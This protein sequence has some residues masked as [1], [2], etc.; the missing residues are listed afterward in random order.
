MKRSISLLGMAALCLALVFQSCKKDKMSDIVDATDPMDHISSEALEAYDKFG[1][2]LEKAID[3]ALESEIFKFSLMDLTLKKEMGDYET[4]MTTFLDHKTKKGIKMK[5]IL[6]EHAIGIFDEE[7]LDNFLREYPALIIATRGNLISWA[8]NEYVAPVVFVHSGFDEKETAIKG[9]RQGESIEIKLDKKFKDAV[10]VM[11]ISERHDALGNPIEPERLTSGS[12]VSIKE[13]SIN[14]SG[15]EKAGM[16]LCD[17]EPT[18]CSAPTIDVF[19]AENINGGLRLTYEIDNFPS[20][21]CYWGFVTITRTGPDTDGDGE[22]EIETFLRRA[23]QSRVFY[24]ITAVPNTE[25]TYEITATIKYLQNGIGWVYCNSENS[26]STTI[27]SGDI[28]PRLD[29]FRGENYSSTQLNYLWTPPNDIP[30]T[31]YRLRVLTPNGYEEI[32]ESP[33]NVGSNNTILYNHPLSYRG[34]LV[35]MQAQ[36]RTSSGIWSGDF[37]DKSFASFREPNQPLHW[38]GIRV[39]D[40]E[41]YELGTY[42]ENLLYGAPEIRIFA[43]RGTGT[44][45]EKKS[46]VVLHKVVFTTPLCYEYIE[47]WNPFFGTYLTIS[48]SNGEYY[49]DNSL[50]PIEILK[51]WENYL[52]GQAVKVVIKETDSPEINFD[53]GSNETTNETKLSAEVGIKAPVVGG[54]FGSIGIESTWTNAEEVSYVYPSSDIEIDLFDI[55]YHYPLLLPRNHNLYGYQIGSVNENG[56]FNNVTCTFLSNYLD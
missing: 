15:V 7:M 21:L 25:Y 36:Y 37:F 45:D 5:D 32:P 40:V 50:K 51:Y 3:L 33:I 31:Q 42:G 9:L 55:Y 49:A 20:E 52:I 11:H 26:L 8:K 47:I 6:L 23:D 19:I 41:A 12:S 4:L 2:G 16:V 18:S 28:L 22:L 29:S 53:E 34:E 17:P 14:M 10:V 24:D 56:S 46:D 30:V 39:P 1:I 38:Y 35:Q 43:I 54:G 27:T 13:P 44:V 48:I